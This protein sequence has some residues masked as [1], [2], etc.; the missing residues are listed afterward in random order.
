M[1]HIL[2]CRIAKA[3]FADAINE[4]TPGLIFSGKSNTLIS[5]APPEVPGGAVM[6]KVSQTSNLGRR[7]RGLGL[8]REYA[9]NTTAIDGSKSVV[10]GLA[11]LHRIVS[12]CSRGHES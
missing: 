9:F 11:C 3:L 4:V 1:S 2:L 6:P 12:E 5:E 8:G 10:I 7:N